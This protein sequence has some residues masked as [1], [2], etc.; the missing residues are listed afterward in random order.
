MRQHNLKLTYCVELLHSIMIDMSLRGNIIS[1]LLF[2]YIQMEDDSIT[3]EPPFL[4]PPINDR[5]NNVGT[6]GHTLQLGQLLRTTETAWCTCRNKRHSETCLDAVS[7]PYTWFTLHVMPI[8]K[9]YYA[10]VQFSVRQIREANHGFAERN[11]EEKKRFMC[12]NI[13]VLG[14]PGKQK[15]MMY[16]VLQRP[17]CR[18]G[19]MVLYH[20]MCGHTLDPYEI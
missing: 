5:E 3:P 19:F 9:L 15:H 20:R 8:M 7:A 16:S 10:W 18:Y 13:R 14:S 17:V 12:D 2:I 1:I 11:R 6:T 4:E